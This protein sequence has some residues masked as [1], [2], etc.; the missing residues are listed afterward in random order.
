MFQFFLFNLKA[1]GCILITGGLMILLDPERVLLS[2]LL[3]TGPLTTM[4]HPLLYYVALGIAILGLTLAGAGILG[5][6][7]SCIHSYFMLTI[8]RI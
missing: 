2:R 8:V 4:A 7:A 3:A 1:C 5:C 6:W